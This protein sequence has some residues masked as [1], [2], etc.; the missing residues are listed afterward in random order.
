M[1]NILTIDVEGWESALSGLYGKIVQTRDEILKNI[2]DLLE[3]FE[4]YNSKGTFFFLGEVAEKFP[5]LL[6]DVLNQGNEIAYHGYYHRDLS[7]ISFKELKEELKKGKDIIEQ[8]IG[9]KIIGFRAPNFTLMKC[10]IEIFDL[11]LDLGFKYDS[12]IFPYKK[13][14]EFIP[15]LKPFRLKTPSGREIFEVPLSVISIFGFKIPCLGGAFLRN[16]PFF[17]TK[18][19]IKKIQKEKR[20][21]IF[22]IHPHEF[23]EI[24]LKNINVKLNVLRKFFEKRGRKKA[25]FYLENLLEGFKFDKI[26]KI[27]ENEVGN[28]G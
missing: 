23:Q 27:Y 5:F 17:F 2:Y 12:S 8:I 21:A 11:L 25:K 22:Y 14:N 1:N 4:K 19:A 7:K 28:F 9:K 20:L 16:Y 15:P 3:I 26:E 18:Y 10:K 13:C 24:N 6:K